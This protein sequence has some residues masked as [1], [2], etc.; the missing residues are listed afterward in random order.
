MSIRDR[1]DTLSRGELAGLAVVVAVTLAGA[2][3][4]YTRS[5]P[6]PVEIA[7][8]SRVVSPGASAAAAGFTSPS[9]TQVPVIVDVAG[10]VKNPG[11]YEFVQ[12]DRVIDA[13]NRA[14]GA[15]N[16]ADL[17]SI[18]LAAL[19]T[20]GAQVVIPKAGA[21]GALG[22]GSSATGPGGT[23]L[24]NIN[25]ASETELEALSGVGPVLAGAIIQYRTEH[26]PFASIDDLVD[27]SGIGP[28]T[29]EELR[30]QVTV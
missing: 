28:S 8:P 23:V 20:D 29:L 5:L 26:G 16:G 10:W 17:S 4:W 15:K 24:V 9:P 25:T 13:V 27:V 30:P 21:G 11:V 18:N 19:L 7:A 12:G 14:G 1:L 3:L 2:G 6:R 22:S